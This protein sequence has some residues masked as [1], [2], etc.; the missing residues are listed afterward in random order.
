MKQ[1]LDEQPEQRHSLH[2]PSHLNKL[3]F[4]EKKVFSFAGIIRIIAV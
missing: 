1:T 4:Q 2:L 3:R